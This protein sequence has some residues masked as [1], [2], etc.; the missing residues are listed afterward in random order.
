MESQT[1]YGASKFPYPDFAVVRLWLAEYERD[2][3]LANLNSLHLSA[4][5]MF[6]KLSTY[7][8]EQNAGRVKDGQA[9]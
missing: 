8:M 3:S 5:I 2:G 6:S 9:K 4:G 7:T 1:P